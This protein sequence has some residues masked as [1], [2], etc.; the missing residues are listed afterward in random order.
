MRNL[1]LIVAYD[2]TDYFG[3]QLNPTRRPSSAAS[4]R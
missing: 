1:R 3:W 2:G 4:N